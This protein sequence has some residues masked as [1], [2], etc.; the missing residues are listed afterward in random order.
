MGGTFDPVHYG[1]L[2]AAE[3]ARCEFKLEEVVFVPTGNPPHKITW[4][5]SSAEH[6]YMM[7]MLATATNPHFDVSRTEIERKGT[8]FSIQTIREFQAEYSDNDA[9]IFFITGFDAVMELLT[10]SEPM[11]VIKRATVIAVT[12]PGYDSKQL[13]A[14]LGGKVLSRIRLLQAPALAISST[15]IRRRVSMGLPIKYLLPEPVEKYIIK[16]GL[17]KSAAR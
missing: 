3:Q 16:N 15:D 12:R 14:A 10:W 4:E 1:H 5:M 9:E 13:H 11:E 7:T 6:R 8:S 17:Y 2:L